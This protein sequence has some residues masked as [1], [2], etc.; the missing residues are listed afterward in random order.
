MEAVHASPAATAPEYLGWLESLPDG[1]P[2]WKRLAGHLTVG[3]TYFF[4]D[5]PCFR[6]LREHVLAPLVAA[7]RAAGIRRLRL[8]SAGCATG[9]E[10]YSLAIVLDDCLPEWSLWAVTILATDINAAAL[11]T[12]RCGVYR[13]WS[14]RQTPPWLRDRYFCRREPGSWELVPRIRQ[15][16]T[17]VPLNLAA[18][19]YPSILTNTTAMDVVV[20]RNVLMYFTPAA[21]RAAAARLAASLVPG[22]WLVVSPADAPGHA[23]ALLAPVNFPGAMFYRKDAEAATAGS[24]PG[25]DATDL[26]E[27]LDIPADTMPTASTPPAPGRLADEPAGC[28]SDLERARE[29]ADQ[30]SLEKARL[31]CEAALER[32][33]LDPEAHILLAAIC[34][35]R[36]DITSAVEALR[37]VIYLAP[38]SAPAHFLMGSLL[39]RQGER[40]LARRCME[41]VVD[42]LDSASPDEV[43]RSSDGL[44]AGRLLET[45]RA[46]LELPS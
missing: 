38:D 8:W 26:P 17:F 12:A 19:G 45:A 22:G 32:D 11:E 39:L 24:R 16:V 43:I 31:L 44:M 6:A 25:P 15:M 1:H 30:G 41:T 2:E 35:E 23:Y 9:E 18:D 7:R 20:C 13:E 3:E 36:G 37:R 34:Q 46:Y 40:A 10:A 29:L 4:R 28:P 33:R 14:F 27:W 42:L 21:Q 5:G